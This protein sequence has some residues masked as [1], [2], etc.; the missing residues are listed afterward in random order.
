VN[1]QVPIIS[2]V[3]VLQRVLDQQ[4]VQQTQWCKNP[5]KSLLQKLGKDPTPPIERLKDVLSVAPRKETEIIDVTFA[6]SSAKEAQLILNAVLDH[7]I[8]YIGEMSDVTELKLNDQLTEQRRILEGG[9]LGR[10]NTIDNLRASLGTAIPQELIS[11]KRVRLDQTQARLAEVRQNIDLLKWELN[12]VSAN[13][14]NDANLAVAGDMENQPQYYEDEEWRRLDANVRSFRHEIGA[15]SRR[16]EHPAAIRS[17]KDLKFTEELL[18]QRETQL[19]EQWRRRAPVTVAGGNHLSYE[20]AAT[21]LK[22]QLARAELEEQLVF[23]DFEKQQTEFDRLFE[24]AQNLERQNTTL[25]HERELFDAVRQRLDQ[26]NL[27]RNAPGSIEVLMRAV[28]AS[29]PYND[30]RIVFTVMATVLALGAGSGVAFLRASRSGAIYAP[31][32]M[33]YPMQIPFLGYVLV[34]D[35]G[36][37]VMK[38]LISR[39]KQVKRDQS[40]ENE[41]MRI[42]RT[43][44]LARLNGQDGT[45]VLIT[46]AAAGTGKSSF[47]M[48]LGESLA[49][50]GKK[51]LIIDAD[52]RKM[53]LTKRLC[54]LD[55]PGFIQ[56]L[57]TGFVQRRH[58]V[59]SEVSGLSFLPAGERGGTGMVY[60]KI[61]N[62]VLTT[63]IDKLRQRYD[64][65]LLDSP[66]IL[67]V[68][69]ATILSGQVDGTIMVERELV[70]HRNNE[71]GALTRLTSGGGRLVGTVFVGSA[72]HEE[73]GEY[74]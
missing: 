68:A 43:A 36:R 38:S 70:S 37:S 61:A 52:L 13:D 46:S 20:E 21:Y 41:S 50:A 62:G 59:Q 12:Q 22:H 71:I 74:G 6:D 42:V 32:D 47:T 69:D 34:T 33:P 49:M 35:T 29:Q 11:Q 65:I 24:S 57:S 16:A 53:T 8:R 60:E 26:K 44:L 66:P 30:R 3:P 51:V 39:Y 19:D 67:S 63:C 27:E 25:S 15:G 58:I 28:T 40:S 64:I 1:T 17:Q 48:M 4:E 9:I 73:Y 14:S 18:R 31:E 56:S 72:R 10:E 5:P 45:S 55:K 23:T 7:Y 54:L 2:S